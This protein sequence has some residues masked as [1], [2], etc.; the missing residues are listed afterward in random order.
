M[1]GGRRDAASKGRENYRWG[2]L[3]RAGKG[4]SPAITS[5]SL[6]LLAVA[7]FAGYPWWHNRTR[8]AARRSRKRKSKGKGQMSKG[9]SE[10]P[11]LKNT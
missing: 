10:R 8:S 5:V 4:L 3:A 9:K 7:L 2:L 1:Q 6:L 11:Q